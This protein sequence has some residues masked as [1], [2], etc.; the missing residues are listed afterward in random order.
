MLTTPLPL[1]VDFL[2][3]VRGVTILGRSL[4]AEAKHAATALLRLD[5]GLPF[6]DTRSGNQPE[7]E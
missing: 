6:G 7:V 5:S 1:D 4:H 3:I 2:L